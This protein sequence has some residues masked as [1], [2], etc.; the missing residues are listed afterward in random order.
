VKGTRSTTP[1]RALAL[2]ERDGCR[3]LSETGIQW[4][5]GGENEVRAIV[6]AA[7]D[8]SSLSDELAAHDAN[9]ETRYHLARERGSIMR[10][11]DIPADA[12]VLE[13]GAGCG[14]VTRY[15]GET[16]GTVDALEPVPQRAAVARLR[17]RDLPSV[18]VFV[19][20]LEAIPE[21]P[22]YDLIAMVG[23][24]EYV[25]GRDD[26]EARI[27]WLRQAAA[28]LRPG[29]AIACAIE[30]RLGV[31]Y[32]AG[33]SEEHLARPFEGLEDYPLPGPVRTFARADLERLFRRAGLTPRTLHVFPDYK[34]PR[35][36]YADT[37]LDSPARPLAWRAPTFPSSAS[38]HHRP[39]MVSEAL[40]WRGLVQ[41]G[42]GGEFA[43]SFLVIAGTGEATPLWPAG[44]H[45]TF[46]SCG[47]RACYA[48]ETRI[49]ASGDHVVLRRR[50]TGPPAPVSTTGLEHRVE[51]SRWYSDPPL[52][53]RLERADPDEMAELLRRWERQV[54][55]PSTRAAPADIDAGPHHALLADDGRMRMIDREWFSSQYSTGDVMARGLLH[56]ALRL[57]DRR[58]PGE[59]PSACARVR[60][61]VPYLAGLAG[62]EASVADLGAVVQREAELLVEITRCAPGTPGWNAA[63]L[64][65]VA[66]FS[67]ALD[68]PLG[69]TALGRRDIAPPGGDAALRAAQTELD[70]VRRQLAASGE[71]IEASGYELAQLRAAHEAVVSSRSWRLTSGVRR[72]ARRLR[73]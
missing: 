19:G 30:N 32:L 13:V 24:L 34:F 8:L 63:L 51:D 65:Q 31:Q 46:L 15:L 66:H 73:S 5:D 3:L 12:T 47:R 18:D 36:V 50:R 70:G 58:P 64:R 62:A 69:E 56:L 59:W 14:A 41:A 57:A 48:T 28:R 11:L 52:V 27:A 10:A 4:L 68:R 40:L 21:E 71:R 1:L 16:A 67:A 49:D 26:L 23:V 39:R 35:L 44:R 9:W 55:R 72:L 33:A 7:H 45:G 38:P 43:N 25:G 22:A 20:A 53:E 2:A 54:G 29:G 61:L 6:A 17:C 60:D 42:L 37:L